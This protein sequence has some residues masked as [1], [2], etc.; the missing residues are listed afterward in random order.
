MNPLKYGNITPLYAATASE[1]ADLNGKVS[2][3]LYL[4]SS[5][6]TARSRMLVREKF[7]IPWARIG[8]LPVG[9]DDPQ[10]SANLW[11]WCEKQV[12]GRR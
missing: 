2:A 5:H 4:D 11:K 8:K 12:A 7:L 1:A 10:N 9:S 3:Y 6:M